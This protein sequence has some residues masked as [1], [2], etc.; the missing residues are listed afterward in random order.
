MRDNGQHVKALDD[1]PET[2]PIINWY[3]D[4]YRRLKA[5]KAEQDPITLSDIL[6]YLELFDNIGSVDEFVDIMQ[7]I[8]DIIADDY[9]SRQEPKNDR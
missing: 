8:D 3:L 7:E 6:A 9:M 1:E 5:G 2:N 4:S